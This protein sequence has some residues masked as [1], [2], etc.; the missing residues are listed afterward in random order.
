MRRF[1]APISSRVGRRRGFT[2]IELLVVIAIIAILIALLLPAVQQAREAARRTDCKSKMHN[3]ALA[4]HN[5]HDVYNQFPPGITSEPAPQTCSG[6]GP[7]YRSPAVGHLTFLLPYMELN[8]V[9]E[10]MTNINKSFNPPSGSPWWSNPSYTMAT[11]KIKSY[12]CPSID[13][14]QAPHAVAFNHSYCGAPCP[15]GMT[16]WYFPN[17]Q[18]LGRT[19]YLGCA[20]GLGHVNSSGWDRWKGIFYS[21]SQTRFRDVTDGTSNTLMFGEHTGDSNYGFSWAGSNGFPTAWNYGTADSW[22]RF[23]SRHP[24]TVNWALADG[25]VRSMSKNINTTVYRRLSGMQDGDT[26]NDW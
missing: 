11:T 20:G 18:A 9:Y 3:L 23:S 26:I 25:S 2:L 7:T 14:Y 17:N 15:C 19:T 12:V 16:I 10:G 13:A 22:T 1:H 6:G 21:R 8:N 4:A 5:F 24:N